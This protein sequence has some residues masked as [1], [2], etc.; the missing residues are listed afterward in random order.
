[1]LQ[2]E[3]NKLAVL[4]QSTQGQQDALALQAR[5]QAIAGRGRFH[6]RFQPTL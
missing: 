5:E 2:N 6:T 1:M 4:A 3:Q